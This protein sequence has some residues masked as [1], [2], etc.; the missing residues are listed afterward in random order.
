MEYNLQLTILSNFLINYLL[1][2]S[3]IYRIIHQKYS[4]KNH[5]LIIQYLIFGKTIHIL[6]YMNYLFNLFFTNVILG[7]NF[8]ANY[9]LHNCF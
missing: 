8:T 7:W 6:K 2:L 5:P 4:F 3:I 9:L 1:A